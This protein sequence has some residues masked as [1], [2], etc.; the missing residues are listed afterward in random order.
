MENE[1]QDILT[2][3]F[4]N[5]ITDPQELEDTFNGFLSLNLKDS[6]NTSFVYIRLIN[7][8]KSLINYLES[9]LIKKDRLTMNIK[10]VILK[11]MVRLIKIKKECLSENINYI[12][13]F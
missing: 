2:S 10:K 11:F 3:L 1:I 8:K 9:A 13:V 4:N 7:S 12:M 5:K 6:K